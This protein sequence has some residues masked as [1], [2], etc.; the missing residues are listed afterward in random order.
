[1]QNMGQRYY[2]NATLQTPGIKQV[3]IIQGVHFTFLSP[4]LYI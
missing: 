4:L 3:G 2:K 1:M